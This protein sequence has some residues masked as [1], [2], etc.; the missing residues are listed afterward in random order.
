MNEVK[1]LALITGGAR[2]GK[3]AF[4]ESFAEQFSGDVF[5]I[6]TMQEFDGD[7]ESVARIQVHRKRRPSHW[8]TME[9]PIDVHI[10]IGELPAGQG[11]CL[12]DCLSLYISNVLLSCT[13]A[14]LSHVEDKVLKASGLLLE[15][16]KERNDKQF[17]VVTNEV[18]WGI[19]PEN[20]LARQYRDLLG[21]ANQ[22]FA[23]AASQV[24]LSCSG[25]QLSLKPLL[26]FLAPGQPR[27]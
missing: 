18:G 7:L 1:N 5:Y 20:D 16:I 17:I 8:Q 26:P 27:A 25:L 19:V 9:V 3:S 24:W 6:A 15:S 4:A 12:I 2:S 23:K 11:V 22:Q 13:P 14:E 10:K 21:L